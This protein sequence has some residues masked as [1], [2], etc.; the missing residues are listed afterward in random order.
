MDKILIRLCIGLLKFFLPK[1][2]FEVLTGDLLEQYEEMLNSSKLRACSWLLKQSL[3]SCMAFAFTIKNF[4]QA[5]L[6]FLG[7]FLFS[8][9]ALGIMYLSGMDDGAKLSEGFWYHWQAGKP[10]QLFFERDFWVSIFDGRLESSIGMWVDLKAIA[11]AILA[12]FLLYRI[13]GL[14]QLQLR[15]YFF[16][17]MIFMCLP[18][19]TG[20]F[21]LILLDPELRMTGPIVASMWFSVLYLVIPTSY[22]LAQKVKRTSFFVSA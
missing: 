18:Y 5:I 7:F 15:M 3:L 12:S 8:I 10:H 17:S 4:L 1:H 2:I 19:V 13:D 11:Y 14:F 22:M 6:V 16:I 21:V 20:S 9:L